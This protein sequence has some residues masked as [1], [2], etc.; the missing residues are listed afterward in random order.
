MKRRIVSIVFALCLCLALLPSTALAAEPATETADFTASDG[1]C[2]A[3]R[4]EMGQ[5]RELHMGQ[6]H[7]NADIERRQLPNYGGHRGEA[8]RGE[9]HRAGG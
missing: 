6:R 9:H 7:Q 3:Q 4:G 2:S 8:S 1:D 5:C